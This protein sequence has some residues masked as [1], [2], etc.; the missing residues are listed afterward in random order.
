MR[1]FGPSRLLFAAVAEGTGAEVAG[2]VA[3][4]GEPRRWGG[5][6]VRRHRV[7]E[8]GHFFALAELFG[9]DDQQVVAREGALQQAGHFGDFVGI[10]YG[11]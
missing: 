11:V 8:R 6:D 1:N 5:G 3:H 2:E 4:E 9:V 10:G 7:D